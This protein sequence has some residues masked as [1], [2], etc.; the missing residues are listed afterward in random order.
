MRH[1]IHVAQIRFMPHK[2]EVR[3]NTDRLMGVLAQLA[4]R[5][6]DVVVTPECL[7]D[8]Y[9]AT[10]ASVTPEDLLGWAVDPSTSAITRDVSAWS[11]DHKA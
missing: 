11:A 8:G 3:W 4:G 2:G 5:D 6:V 10:E 1:D 7:L 9:A